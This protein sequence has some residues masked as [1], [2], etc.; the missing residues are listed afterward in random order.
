MEGLHGKACRIQG[1]TRKQALAVAENSVAQQGRGAVRKYQ[2]DIIA[3]EQLHEARVEVVT[4]RISARG[5]RI[6]DDR[7]VD[8]RSRSRISARLGPEQVG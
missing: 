2:I 4:P 5:G 3:V 1:V 7:K 8:I 6:E